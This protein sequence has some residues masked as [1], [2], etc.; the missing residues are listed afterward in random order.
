MTT[1]R[2][3]KRSADVKKNVIASFGI[4]G[5][6]ILVYFLLV[7]LTLGYLNKYE[8]GI[9]LTLNS[10]LMWINSFDIG[11]GNGLRNKLVDALAAGD[12]R[13]CKIYVSTTFFMLCMLMG[14]LMLIGS[15]L[16][17]F[18]DWYT[19]LGASRESI[20]NLD[21][22]VY[23]SFVLFC[24]NFILKFVGNV[25]LALQMPAV[26][27]LF[28]C[29]G[30]SLSLLI[31]FILS[32]YTE[33]SF[34]YV[35]V[36]YGIAPPLVYLIV[37]AITFF[38]KYGYMSPS[39]RYFRREYLK[40]LF[41]MGVLFFII[42]LGG[43][44]LFSTANL[45][46][47]HL[48]GPENVTPYNIAYRY[49]SVVSI[50]MNLI[51][52]PLWSAATDAYV[53]GEIGWIRDSIAKIRKLLLLVGAGI[54]AMILLSGTA[55]RLWLGDQITIPP[56]LTI[57]MGSYIFIL[58]WSM[59]F[60]NFLN[61]MGK[62]RIQAINTIVV[63]ILFVPVGLFLGKSM[64]SYGIVLSLCLANLPGAVL[65]TIQLKKVVAN[66]ASGIWAE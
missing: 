61:G 14:I 64:G 56:A 44:L 39:V 7:P 16:Y 41:S 35:A 6:D 43:L 42:Q 54:V 63:G 9:W 45:I 30:H 12:K 36:A 23:L 40:S 4:K 1:L 11:L 18:L 2:G 38:G 33:G 10:I 58:V 27:N 48:F 49:F 13:L 51:I 20:R 66:R 59:S 24:F 50:G 5:V 21:Q 47:S 28:V 34:L 3:D 19:I 65:N 29:L 60:S 46:I 15:L 55:Y 31:I 22:I 17:P 57:G 37:Y 52:A 62:L 25:Y 26:N 8:Y 53:R 32:R